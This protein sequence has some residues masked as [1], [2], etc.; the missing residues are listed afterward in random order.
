MKI[1]YINENKIFI[2]NFTHCVQNIINSSRKLSQ[3]ILIRKR[4]NMTTNK[5]NS[6]KLATLLAATTILGGSLPVAALADEANNG[7]TQ[8]SK[9]GNT[10]TNEMRQSILSANEDLQNLNNTY[11]ES[12]TDLQNKLAEL[13]AESNSLNIK[14]TTD[15]QEVAVSFDEYLDSDSVPT[16]LNKI[17]N[18]T[19]NFNDAVAKADQHNEEV[20]AEIQKV[21]EDYQKAVKEYQDKLDQIASDFDTQHEAWEQ[22]VKEI[23]DK[24]DQDT[25]DWQ[26]EVNR[27]NQENQNKKNDYDQDVNKY[28]A[29]HAQWEKDIKQYNEVDY[30]KYQQ[31]KAVYDEYVNNMHPSEHALD[32]QDIN[33]GLDIQ[34]EAAPNFNVELLRPDLKISTP[35][36][37]IFSFQS[38]NVRDIVPTSEHP[39]KLDGPLFRATYDGLTKSSYTDTKGVKHTIGKIVVTGS[40]WDGRSARPTLAMRL[41]D[42]VTDGFWLYFAKTGLDVTY[43]LFDTNGQPIQIED[44]NAWLPVKSLNTNMGVLRESVG[45]V[46]NSQNYE[47]I[48]SNTKWHADGLYGEANSDDN[49][50]DPG[51]IKITNS[52]FTVNYGAI[53]DDGNI[54]LINA[55]YGLSTEMPT[56]L[57]P[58]KPVEPKKP[59]EPTKPIEPT[60]EN[61]PVKPTQPDLPTEPV[62]QTD[63][64]KP[65]V[66]TWNKTLWTVPLLQMAPVP[67]VGNVIPE[68]KTE[69]KKYVLPHTSAKHNNGIYIPNVAGLA[70]LT[71]LL[72]MARKR[73]I[74][75][76]QQN[77]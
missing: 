39:A 3:T 54:G 27:I 7:G 57:A 76:K 33:Q 18:N 41:S 77:N 48:G 38:K 55:W 11:L 6:H 15:E 59:V 31:E 22:E 44:G 1:I 12:F 68:T 16:L 32:V 51:L 45:A 4:M 70:G 53:F 2:N 26:N 71:A 75:D 52:K 69:E 30:P 24:F 25:Q 47:I 34:P 46:E 62:K 21:N 58:T 19:N 65:S 67:V 72:Y 43:E 23:Q 49:V 50:Y 42:M 56:T 20:L 66:P 9:S 36:S 37:N 64:K 73:Q 10:V 17:D 40:N 14:N 61:T 63:P 35:T 8:K 60:Y 28:N 5:R 29:D 74:K 13:V